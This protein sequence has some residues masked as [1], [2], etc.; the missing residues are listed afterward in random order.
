MSS[1]GCGA[2][3]G[4]SKFVRGEAIAS[5]ITIAVNVFGGIII[6]T[7]RHGMPLARRPTCSPSSRWATASSRRSP[8]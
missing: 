8:P 6:G 5:L 2:M 4:A 3:D 1:K 7:T